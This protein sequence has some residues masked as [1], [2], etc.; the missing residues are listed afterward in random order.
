M[1]F[2]KANLAI[3]LLALSSPPAGAAPTT[4]G[5]VLTL[6]RTWTGT[7]WY[8]SFGQGVACPGDV[9]GDGTSDFAV[10]DP[11]FI[12][13]VHVPSQEGRIRMLS[14]RTG[15]VLWDALNPI[16]AYNFGLAMAAA[17]DVNRDGTPDLLVSSRTGTGVFGWYVGIVNVLSGK[18]GRPLLGWSSPPVLGEAVGWSLAPAGDLD[19]DAYPDLLIGAEPRDVGVTTHVVALS[20]RTAQPLFQWTGANPGDGFG[21][22]VAGI[23]DVNQD[24]RPDVA[25]GARSGAPTGAGGYWGEVRVFSGATGA[26]LWSQDGN[27]GQPPP[28]F[29]DTGNFGY[30]LCPTADQDGDGIPDLLVGAPGIESSYPERTVHLLSGATGQRLRVYPAPDPGALGFGRRIALI[31][32]HLL[33][34]APL[35]DQWAGRLY[36]LDV[37]SGALKD[38]CSGEEIL[39][40]LGGSWTNGLAVGRARDGTPL[41]A[42]SAMNAGP[43]YFFPGPPPFT[44]GAGEAYLYGLR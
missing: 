43:G 12:P 7:Q 31:D 26:L 14:G 17:G 42:V 3:L 41:V 1:R 9:D 27:R 4:T 37:L 18:D 25:V 13:A 34:A 11:E 5:G 44:N 15:A 39:D 22:A 35:A 24:G 29:G 38:T 6:R 8:E 19:G 28:A 40:A 21:W 20:G 16:P 32:Q 36:V 10:G 33:V 30:A 2:A 23:G